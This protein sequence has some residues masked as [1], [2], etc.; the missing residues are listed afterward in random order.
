[1]R[2]DENVYFPRGNQQALQPGFVEGRS[3]LFH[4]HLPA[5]HYVEETAIE[6]H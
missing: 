4:R 3:Q 2:H 6:C 1:M 5:H